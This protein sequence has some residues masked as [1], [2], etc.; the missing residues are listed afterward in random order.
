MAEGAELRIATDDPSYRLWI[1]ERVTDHP[2]FDWLA[3]GPDD[4]SRRPTD[5][6]PTRYEAK[7]VKAGRKPVYLRLR[8]RGSAREKA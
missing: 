2:W 1:L 7:A 5:W 6:P 4:W 3:G 8:R